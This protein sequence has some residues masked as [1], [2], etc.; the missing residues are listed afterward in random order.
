MKK[1]IDTTKYHSTKSPCYCPWPTKFYCPVSP[2]ITWH[3]GLVYKDCPL[4]E[5]QRDMA[6]CAECHLRGEGTF[7]LIKKAERKRKRPYNKKK[8]GK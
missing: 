3:K 1:Q 6:H 7:R 4:A 2:E 5:D 8:K